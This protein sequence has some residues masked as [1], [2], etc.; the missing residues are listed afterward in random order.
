MQGLIPVA[1]GVWRWTTPDP[2]EETMMVGHLLES[3]DGIVLIDPPVVPGITGWLRVLGGVT[4]IVLTTHDH[5]R[6]AFWLS[7]RFGAPVYAPVQADSDVLQRARLGS[8]V[9]YADGDLVPGGLT[10]RRMRV[11][12]P[13]NDPHTPYLD[14]M[15]LM[16]DGGA[17]VLVGDVVSLSPAGELRGCPS[18][19]S[20][21]PDP[22][23]VRASLQAFRATVPDSATTLL[24]PHGQDVVGTL[25]AILAAT[26][27]ST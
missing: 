8:A 24:A 23:K 17:I 19:F 3:D 1:A 7:E 2:A 21:T 9:R 18:E 15:M 14:E 11:M 10:A 13:E 25:R 12:V 27:M 22:A 6:G 5:T 26:P 20:P 16:C 4:A